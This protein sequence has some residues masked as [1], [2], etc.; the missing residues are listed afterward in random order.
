MKPLVLFLVGP[1]ASGKSTIAIELARQ[2]NGEIISADSMLVY[3]GMDIGTAK[4]SKA[5]RKKVPHH[6]IDL[7]APSRSFSV[8]DYRK[9]AVAKIREI[10]KR[11]KLPVVA[12][13]SGLYVRAILNGLSIQPG[14]NPV[15]RKKLKA[16]AKQKGL[17][18]LY[19]RLQKADPAR[20]AKIKAGDEKRIIRALEILDRVEKDPALLDKKTESLEELGFRACVIGIEKDRARLYADIER[21]V[22]LMFKKGL[23]VEVKRLLKKGRLSKTALQ[24]VGYKEIVDCLRGRCSQQ[25][26]KDLIKKNSRHLAKRQ[27]TWFRREAGIQWISWREGESLKDIC[28]DVAA[29]VK[30]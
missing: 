1:T 9:R 26:A 14:P 24:A 25:E 28:H 2:L 19:A 16:E 3:K 10:S 23:V 11:G 12:G 17:E 6:L 21:R 29:K 4:P 30:F 13:G 7:F 27:F 20:A 22:D 15:L 18:V 8:F 5:E